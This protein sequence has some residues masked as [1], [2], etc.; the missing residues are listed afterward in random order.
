[1]SQFALGMLAG[2]CVSVPLGPFGIW[3]IHIFVS[4][5]WKAAII[6]A[7]GGV[8]GDIL[9][10]LMY[11][12]GSQIAEFLS[13]GTGALLSTFFLSHVVRGV[14]LIAVGT[15]LIFTALRNTVAE[16][17]LFLTPFLGSV[18]PQNFLLVGIVLTNF[19][20]HAESAKGHLDLILLGF[21]IGG[22][23]TW[24]GFVKVFSLLPWLRENL[25]LILSIGGGLSITAGLYLIFVHT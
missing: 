17:G 6:V 8:T 14:G 16:R 5:G 4:R 19:G 21:S 12:I 3:A 13:P 2:F 9:M 24:I 1:M 25:K 10:V 20:V 15:F 11:L 23:L 18:L 22:L 7:L